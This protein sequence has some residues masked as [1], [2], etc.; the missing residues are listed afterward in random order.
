MI[1]APLKFFGKIMVLL[2]IVG[3]FLQLAFAILSVVASPN[4]GAGTISY[5]IGRV[6]G[7]LLLLLILMLIFR[8]LNRK[9]EAGSSPKIDVPNSDQG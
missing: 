1:S 3:V 9:K 5:S 7:D 6:T 4:S 8:R 2:L